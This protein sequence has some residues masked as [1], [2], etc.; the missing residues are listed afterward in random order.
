M[1]EKINRIIT[2]RYDGCVR[3]GVARCF[4]IP[5]KD[6]TKL[7]RIGARSEKEKRLSNAEQVP[8]G[9]NYMRSILKRTSNGQHTGREDIVTENNEKQSAYHS[10]CHRVRV[11]STDLVPKRL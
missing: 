11:D 1:D 4:D 8:F 9:F 10:Y 6:A 7:S 2:A 3:G 5:W